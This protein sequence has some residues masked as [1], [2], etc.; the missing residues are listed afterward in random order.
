VTETSPTAP[1]LVWFRR[2]L[3]LADH[4]ALAAAVA[5]GRP[6]LPAFI[7][8]PE[9]ET[10]WEPGAA[11]RWWLHRSLH[12]LQAALAGWEVPLVLR[13]GP[14]A[15]ALVAL[16][17]E[18]SAAEVYW[19]RGDTP[20][21]REQDDTV[22][23]A[24]SGAGIRARRLPGAG[25]LW[26][27]EELCAS[28][29]SSAPPRLFAAFWRAC[30]RLPEPASP[31]P[32]PVALT[33]P[34]AVPASLALQDLGLEPK[35]AWD[36]GLRAT[37]VPGEG[38]AQ[39]RLHA[40]LGEGLMHYA[41]QRNRPDLEG[42]SRL[43]PHLAS[44]EIS[45][46]AIWHAVRTATLVDPRLGDGGDAFLRELGWREYCAH[47]LLS[48]PHVADR[49]M[50]QEF[51]AF[52]WREDGAALRAWQRGLTGEPLVDAGMR[53]LW[54]TGWMHNRVRMVA[55]SYLTRHLLLPWE[56]GARWFWDTLVDADL[57]SNSV[58]WQWV[59]GTGTDAAPYFRIFNPRLQAARF[60]PRGT[61]V[62]R[63]IPELEDDR[64]EYPPPLVDHAT[65]RAR[66]L[67]AYAAL[68]R[69]GAS[70]ARPDTEP[71]NG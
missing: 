37:W 22:V 4:P 50:R 26:S 57:A 51:V 35:V 21:A 8:S 40:F 28:R 12:S 20:V 63:W 15:A 42:T 32:A 53:Q 65:A 33:A 27:P 25:L 7:W 24:L 64:R 16:A 62:R 18:V 54:A 45:A 47:L 38:R 70:G 29:G 30:L 6:I 41:E 44:G 48:Q 59:A 49:P 69:A 58:N 34:A 60:D 31:L 56:H 52:P 46:R 2:D 17:R 36:A 1:A 5:T 13:R 55:A 3:R 14:A 71:G 61:Y 11:A 66:A 9:E 67:A 23:A 68:R 10:P 43:S 39:A 19:H